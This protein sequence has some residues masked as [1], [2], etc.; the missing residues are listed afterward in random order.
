MADDLLTPFQGLFR[1]NT[2]FFVRH[3]APF[4]KDEGKNKLAATWCGVAT[5]GS[6][7]FPDI[8]EGKEKGDYVPVTRE[9]YREHLNGGSGLAIAPITNTSKKD[10]ACYF[11]AIDIDVYDTNFIRLVQRLS[12]AGFK[13]ASFLSKSGG[14]HIYFFFSAPESAKDAI[15]TLK[16]VVRVFGL[17]KIYR[18]G[19]SGKVEIFPKQSVIA[20][21]G[22]SANALFLPFYNSAGDCPNK[23]LTPEG[24]LIGIAKAIPLMEANFTSL[25]EINKTI[26][27]LPYSDAPYCIQTVLLNGL[28]SAGDHRNDFLFSSAIYLKKKYGGDF[29]D[30]LLEMNGLLGDPMEERDVEA[31]Y[32]SVT[33]TD[34]SYDNY[35]CTKSPCCD[36][37]DKG[38]CANREFGKTVGGKKSK[39]TGAEW[40]G[41]VTE[42]VAPGGIVQHYLWDVLPEG[43]TESKTVRIDRIEDFDNQSAIRTAC[44]RDLGWSPTVVSPPAWVV[45]TNNSMLGM[46]DRRI[47]IAKEA[48]TSEDVLLRSAVYRYLTHKQIQNGQPFMIKTGQVYHG[49]G[50]Y[51][52]TTDGLLRFLNG[53]R[54]AFYKKNLYAKLV[55][56]GCESAVITYETSKGAKV[57]IEC[58][59]KQEDEELL[60]MGSYYD[61]VYEGESDIINKTFKPKQEGQK[62]D[63][64]F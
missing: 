1:G 32:R 16:N 26:K 31:T 24:K 39:L 59:K 38:E 15:Q 58:W 44:R 53:E 48:G 60:E 18:R 46:K 51:H 50:Y 33:D 22:A 34:K 42:V 2:S 28:L 63:V 7:S 57:K 40:W 12:E 23:M 30:Y 25:D 21:G 11:A 10:N 56:M 55:E 3:E 47:E 35:G 64:K 45:I 61:D 20:P 36:Y 37:C 29:K 41:K 9:L 14:L 52:F 27:A 6:K 4:I 54:F 19:S 62:E 43:E 8:P 49:E 17:E 13:F 5:Y